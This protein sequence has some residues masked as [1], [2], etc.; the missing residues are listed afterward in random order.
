MSIRIKPNPSV[1]DVKK[2]LAKLRSDQ[3]I[4]Q[5]KNLVRHFG[6]LKRGLDGMEYQNEVRNEWD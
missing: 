4:P 3:P 5:G 1:E 6:K 2:A